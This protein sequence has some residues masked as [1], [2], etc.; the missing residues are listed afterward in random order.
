MKYSLSLNGSQYNKLKKHLLSDHLESV[1]LILCNQSKSKSQ[2]KLI[3]SEVILIPN[4]ICKRTEFNIT[5]PFEKYFTPRQIEKMEK[6]KL[7]LMTVHSHPKGY[8][9]FSNLDNSNDEVLFSSVNNWFDD[10]RPNGSSIMLPNGHL[11]G[12]VFNDGEGFVSLSHISIAGSSIKILKHEKKDNNVP[13]FGKRIAQ[14]FGTGTFSIL[15]QLKIGVVGCSGTGSIVIELLARNCIGE[16]VIVDPDIIEQKNLNRVLNATLSDAKRLCSKVGVLKKA[17][18][19]LG[20]G[21]KV[22]DYQSTTSDKEVIS[23]LKNCDILFG[24]VD[25]AIGR[26]HLDCI[27]SAYIIPYFDVGVRID[28]DKEGG[29]SQAI[30]TAHYIEPGQS[31]LLSRGAYTSEQVREESLKMQNPAYYEQQK[32]EGYIIGQDED[33]PAVISINMQAAC[34]SFNDFIARIHNHRLDSNCDFSI[35]QISL[36]H[37][38]YRHERDNQGIHPVFSKNFAKAD[39]SELLKLI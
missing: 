4:D 36:T 7:S 22:S 5:W 16:L 27:S 12:R 29:V 8:E 24:C 11:F 6:E 28:A 26:Y 2:T 31:N 13:E 20:M 21:T 25:S 33:Q 32:K 1:A 15:K 30:M 39:Q 34:M 14:T 38:Y 35:Q 23:A 9:D 10:K 17:I 19:E 3:T 37:G 18:Q